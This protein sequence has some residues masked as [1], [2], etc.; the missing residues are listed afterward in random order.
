MVGHRAKFVLM[1]KNAIN[2]NNNLVV[3]FIL[4][5]FAATK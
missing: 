2:Q 4:I 3:S 5:T 1:N